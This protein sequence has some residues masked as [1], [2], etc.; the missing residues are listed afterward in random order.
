M[1]EKKRVSARLLEMMLEIVIMMMACREWA[2]NVFFNEKVDILWDYLNYIYYQF[3]WIISTLIIYTQRPAIYNKSFLVRALMNS[4]H[5]LKWF[6][7][8]SISRILPINFW[9]MLKI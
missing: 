2:E 9:A 6:V 3:N 5:Q 7:V 8:N 4:K 1:L